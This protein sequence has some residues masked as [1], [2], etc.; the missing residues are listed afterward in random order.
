M[1]MTSRVLA[2]DFDISFVAMEKDLE[3]IVRKLFVESRPYSDYL[4]KLLI[5]N[6]K[7]CLDDRK[8]QYQTVIDRVSL[9]DLKDKG[10]IRFTPKFA[11]Q[12]HEDI[13]S[14]IYVAFEDVAP[15]MNTQYNNTAVSVLCM[16]NLDAWELDD[17]AVRPWKIAGYVHGLLNNARLSGIGTLQFVGA[18]QFSFDETLGGVK[19]NYIATN[20][21]DDKQKMSEELDDG[22]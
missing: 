7:D 21:N 3:Q 10:Y 9:A 20:G 15:S 19:L 11:F 6:E 16:C 12:E 8:H 1:K 17:Y 5:V 2:K 18:S 22:R 13:K 14:Y 4:K